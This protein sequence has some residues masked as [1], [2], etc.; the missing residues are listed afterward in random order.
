MYGFSGGFMFQ[1]RAQPS[2]DDKEMLVHFLLEA[3]LS[4]R[5]SGTT[6]LIEVIGVLW[7]IRVEGLSDDVERISPR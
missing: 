2:I 7:V 5:C 4:F 6:V 1:L 3:M